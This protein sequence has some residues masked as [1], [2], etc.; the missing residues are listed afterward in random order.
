M[1][2]LLLIYA[3]NVVI[4]AGLIEPLLVTGCRNQPK[5]TR[6]QKPIAKMSSLVLW[7][8]AQKVIWRTAAPPS[9]E[10]HAKVPSAAVS[11]LDASLEKRS[12]HVP[13]GGQH[14]EDLGHGVDI[15]PHRSSRLNKHSSAFRDKFCHVTKGHFVDILCC[16]S[17]F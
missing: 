16:K 7:L 2:A 5:I 11:L 1:S 4:Y 9:Q 10:E 12:R 3:D 6:L 17:F 14:K 15:D 8:N 13:P